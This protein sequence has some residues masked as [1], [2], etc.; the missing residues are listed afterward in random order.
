MTERML[1]E[2]LSPCCARASL[3]GVLLLALVLLGGPCLADAPQPPRA[4]A[5]IPFT[6]GPNGGIY[7]TARLN[8][9]VSATFLVDTGVDSD[10][11]SETVAD[12]L[13]LPSLP[14][15]HDGKP[16]TQGGKALQG[17]FVPHVA[18]GPF[19]YPKVAF[20][21]LS[22]DQLPEMPDHHGHVDGILGMPALTPFT[23]LLD[24]GHSRMT[25]WSSA[26][27]SASEMD[28]EGFHPLYTVPIT[29][30]PN[31]PYTWTT[32]VRFS[33]GGK[34]AQQDMIVDTGANRTTVP[35]AVASQL[36]IQKT[37]GGGSDAVSQQEDI[38]CLW[39]CRPDAD[40][41]P[42]LSV[43]PGLLPRAGRP[44]LSG[45]PGHGHLS[46][47]QCAF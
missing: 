4:K 46:R 45:Q 23:I 38:R 44:R 40:R 47:L 39:P 25:F 16:L 12:A 8:D 37:G 33:Q 13:G 19:Q 26:G 18:L 15:T 35:F 3:H 7:V 1:P 29:P 30:L 41:R 22:P 34:T 42:D 21:L 24:F 28:A 10:Y 11:L 14:A 5:V 20:V 17:V 36:G 9:K 27:L 6:L 32:P 31:D 2:Y 43:P